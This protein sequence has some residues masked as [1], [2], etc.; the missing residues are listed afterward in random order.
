MSIFSAAILA[1]KLLAK[2]ADGFLRPYLA[3]TLPPE[4]TLLSL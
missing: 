1:I 4:Y 3:F 2:A